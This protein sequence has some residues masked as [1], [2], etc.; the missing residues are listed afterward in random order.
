MGLRDTPADHI[1]QQEEASGALTCTFE[2]FKQKLLDLI[3]HPANRGEQLS[4]SY[5]KAQQS[6]HQSAQAFDVELAGIEAMLPFCYRLEEL[7]KGIYLAKLVPA[8]KTLVSVAGHTVHT[9]AEAVAEASRL[10]QTDAAR[11]KAL[12][13]YKS[14][15]SGNSKP[16]SLEE[17]ITQPQDNH[18]LQ[19]NPR[20]SNRKARG[21]GQASQ[22]SRTEKSD[23]SE[24]GG[25]SRK[26][27]PEKNNDSCFN[28]GRKGHWANSCPD[29][30]VIG[31]VEEQS[32]NSTAPRKLRCRGGS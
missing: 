1:R 14:Q 28:C 17:R 29:K 31:A 12:H 18:I 2:E 23:N 13:L 22:R 7:R 25:Q 21:G 16:R 11:Q 8:L 3:Q 9:R 26:R 15:G 27:S 4:V 24:T 10:E 19:A 6:E 30:S 20:K 5:N 32:K